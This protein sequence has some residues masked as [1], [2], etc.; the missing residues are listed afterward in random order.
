[1]EIIK[2]KRLPM[3]I[4]LTYTNPDG[5]RYLQVV[6]DHRELTDNRADLL[7][8]TNF[9]LFAAST[10]QKASKFIK[11]GKLGEAEAEIKRFRSLVDEVFS[12]KEKKEDL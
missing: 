5:E 4:Q 8:D 6:N 2:K 9:A 1:M 7:N 10:L 12:K 3:Q 11:E